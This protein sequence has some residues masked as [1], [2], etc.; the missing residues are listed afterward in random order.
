MRPFRSK[1]LD[2]VAA[3]PG[4]YVFYFRKKCLYVGMSTNLKNRLRTHWSGGSHNK[5]LKKWIVTK[6]DSLQVYYVKTMVSQKEKVKRVEDWLIR[7]LNPTLN[8]NI[9]T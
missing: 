6:K 5:S 4:L 9:P 2:Q 1:R 7:R 3:T 8:I